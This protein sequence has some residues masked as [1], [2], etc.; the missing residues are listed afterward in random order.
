MQKHPKYSNFL[1]KNLHLN[2]RKCMVFLT[3]EAGVFFS[4]VHTCRNDAK[5]LKYDNFAVTSALNAGLCY[6]VF[7]KEIGD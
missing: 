3:T 5:S 7:N 4:V 1:P 2:Y 6:T